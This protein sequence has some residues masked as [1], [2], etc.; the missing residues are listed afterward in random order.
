[1]GGCSKEYPI[2]T[3]AL[4]GSGSKGQNYPLSHTAPLGLL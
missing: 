2:P 3:P 1:M 4:T